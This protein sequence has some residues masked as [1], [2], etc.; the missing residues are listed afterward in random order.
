MKSMTIPTIRSQKNKSNLVMITAYDTQMAHIVDNAGVDIILVGD[1][2]GTVVLGHPN[3][4]NVTIENM[5][6]HVSAVAKSVSRCLIVA[7]IPFGSV[8]RGADVLRSHSVDLI[9]AGAHAIK[10]EGSNRLDVISDLVSSGVPVMG[11]LG[12]TPQSINTLGGYRVQGRGEQERN[13]LVKAAGNLEKA[14]VFAMVIECVPSNTAA[15]ITTAVTVPTI[16]IG[17]GNK[18]DGQ[19]LVINDLLAM[20]P[21]FKPR[22]VKQYAQLSDII[23]NA[24]QSYVKEVREGVFPTPEH[25]YKD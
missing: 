22:F 13:A 18:V 15:A 8:Q 3:T 1:S 2:L 9:R 14:G 24:V 11:H 4:L 19:V 10:I 21:E 6:H 20:N 7:D 12:L 17:A 25:E 16:G 5:I 23:S